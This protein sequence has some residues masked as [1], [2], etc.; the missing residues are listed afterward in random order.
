MG[1]YLYTLWVAVYILSPI[2]EQIKLLI[3]LTI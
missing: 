2:Q 1:K 3:D